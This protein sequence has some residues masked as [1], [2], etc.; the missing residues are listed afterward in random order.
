MS[1]GMVSQARLSILAQIKLDKSEITI[2][3]KP[4][5]NDGFGNMIEDPYG[6]SMPYVY[7]VRL[8]HDKK[9]PSSLESSPAGFTSNL[10]RFIIMDYKGGINEGETFSWRDKKYAVGVVDPLTMSGKIIGYQA[11]LKEAV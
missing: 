4:I 11:P 10:Y 5:I 1:R 9:G 6:D 3:R 8:S 7:N 2:M